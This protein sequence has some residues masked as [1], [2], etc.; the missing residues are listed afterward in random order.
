VSEG[1]STKRKLG[2][3]RGGREMRDVGAS[4]VGCGREVRETGGVHG[5]R[6]RTRERAVSGDRR[7][8]SGSGRERARA[9]T[10]RRR[11]I[12]PTRQRARERERGGG[13]RGHGLAPSS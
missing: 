12:G 6:E 11:Q 8:P 9:W 13:E 4:M 5:L 2:A 1:T 10:D 7:G 3:C